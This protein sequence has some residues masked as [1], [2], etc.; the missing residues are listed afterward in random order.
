MEDWK[1]SQS[2]M[3]QTLRGTKREIRELVQVINQLIKSGSQKVLP[4]R[5]LDRIGFTVGLLSQ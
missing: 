1:R 5:G 3:G 2:F 4:A